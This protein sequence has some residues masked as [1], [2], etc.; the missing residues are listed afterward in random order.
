[1]AKGLEGELIDEVL[2]E[3]LETQDPDDPDVELMAAR[4]YVRRRRLGLH[5]PKDER[6]L[7][8]QRDLAALGRAGFSYE[9]ARRALDEDPD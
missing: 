1:M 7:R 8:R 3:E 9:I 2:K 4:A 5:R 6:T